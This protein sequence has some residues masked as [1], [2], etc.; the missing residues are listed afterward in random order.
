MVGL[1]AAFKSNAIDQLVA[2]GRDVR[3]WRTLIHAMM[4]I[5]FDV[6][7]HAE[8]FP[9]HIAR[10]GV[11]RFDESDLAHALFV[12]GRA[13][14]DQ[15]GYGS[16]SVWE[17]VHRSS[18]VPAYIRRTPTGRL[19]KSALADSLDRSEKV[20]VSYAL[21]QALTGIFCEQALGVT[22]LMH[23]DRYA[24]RWRVQFGSTRRR[25]DMFG[26]IGPKRWVVA[27]A[28]GRSNGMESALRQTLIEQ[29]GAVRT[30][31]GYV[32]EIALGCVASFP[33][34]SGGIRGPM[35]VD[36][37]DPEVGKSESFDLSINEGRFLQAYYE[38]FAAAIDSGQ[39]IAVP[40]TGYVAASLGSSGLQ[41]GMREGLYS[42]VQG[43]RGGKEAAWSELLTAVDDGDRRRDGTFVSADY[44]DAL[45]LQDYD[46]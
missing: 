14:G 45:S 37:V 2:A 11:L 28:K 12:T 35:R 17:W 5:M 29:K 26:R 44:G 8:A 10:R 21:G 39:A 27:E 9:G 1:F 19:V 36:A 24:S 20:S 13:P 3:V 46:S 40:P 34:L 43:S 32:P 4:Q 38:P 7:F 15:R 25:A 6:P 30:I 22:H 31:A 23:V 42:A 18:L 33:I 16:T 41:V